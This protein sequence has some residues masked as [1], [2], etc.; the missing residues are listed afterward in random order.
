MKSVTCSVNYHLCVRRWTSCKFNAI[1]HQHTYDNKDICDSCSSVASFESVVF[2]ALFTL[3][4]PEVVDRNKTNLHRVSLPLS[5][6]LFNKVV[7]T[8]YSSCLLLSLSEHHIKGLSH[9]VQ[10]NLYS[11]LK[12]KKVVIIL[13]YAH[14]PFIPRLV[15][16]LRRNSEQTTSKRTS[17]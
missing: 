9:Q 2:A 15:Q 12:K 4:T 17:S 6:A 10:L 1:I 7:Q 14:N 13:F 3:F 8:L 5:A 16:C 11:L